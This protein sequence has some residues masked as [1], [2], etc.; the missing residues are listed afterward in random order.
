ML[1]IFENAKILDKEAIDLLFKQ[2]Q[3]NDLVLEDEK[4]MISSIDGITFS[5]NK[6]GGSINTF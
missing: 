4:R 6:C 3:E 1:I 5:K 2:A